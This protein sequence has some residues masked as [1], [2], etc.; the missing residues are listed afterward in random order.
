MPIPVFDQLSPNFSTFKK[1][2]NRS[3]ESIPSAYVAW[4][5][6]TTTLFLASID[7]LKIPVPILLVLLWPMITLFLIYL[8]HLSYCLLSLS[9]VVH[10][11]AFLVLVWAPWS[12]IYLPSCP[13]AWPQCSSPAWQFSFLVLHLASF[14]SGWHLGPNEAYLSLSGP[15]CS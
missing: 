14:R 11:L 4:R 7:C 5:A 8:F 9:F 12:P 6:G 1:P 15:P 2:K 10:P 13:S 3:K